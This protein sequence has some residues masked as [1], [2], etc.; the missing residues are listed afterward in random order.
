MSLV[1]VVLGPVAANVRE[2]VLALVAQVEEPHPMVANSAGDIPV[3]VDIAAPPVPG[4][5]RPV[6]LLGSSTRFSSVSIR[7][8]MV[9]T[10]A[11][12]IFPWGF[13]GFLAWSSVGSPVS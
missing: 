13:T 4:V 6:K 9:A 2:E 1:D 10:S 5:R 11:R 8:K 7:K 12:V 3:G